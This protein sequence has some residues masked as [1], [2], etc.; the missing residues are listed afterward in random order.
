MR[1]YLVDRSV[2]PWCILDECYAIYT[3]RQRGSGVS[4]AD[5]GGLL[6]C[7]QFSSNL[8]LDWRRSK[9]GNPVSVLRDI[10]VLLVVNLIQREIGPCIAQQHKAPTVV[11]LLRS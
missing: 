7:W 4:R 2:D 8:A 6:I 10:T 3:H 9:S 5:G 11:I 1:C